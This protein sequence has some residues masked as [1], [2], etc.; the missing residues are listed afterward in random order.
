MPV[1]SPGRTAVFVDGC[2]LPFQRAGT[3]Y[4]DLMAYDMGRMVLRHLLTRTGLPSDRVERV[5]MGTV[6][7]DVNTSNVARESALAAGIPNHVPA[8]TVTM[9][10]ISSNQAVTSGVDLLRTGQADVMIAGGTETL[11]D[12]PVRLKRPVRKR[13]FQARKAKSTGDYLDLLD[14]LSPGD[15]LPETPA[16]AEFSTGEVMGESA[17]RLAAMFG[18][19]R[20]D[21]DRYALRSHKK[22]AAAR[23]D[24]RLDEELAPAT[25]PPAFDPIT[26]DNVIRDDTS[27]E[28]LRDLPPAFVEPFGTITAGSSSALTDGASAT[29]LMA[30]EVAEAEGVAP[31]AALRTYTYV[32]QD[33]ETE[34]LLGP[35]YAIPEV[36]DEAGLT[37]DDIDVIELHEAFA[38]QVLAVL[39]A[40]RSDTFAAEHLNRT[41]AVGAVEMDR[42]NTRGGSLS[43]G[44]PFGATGARLVM[45][46][47]NRLHDEDGRWALV[48][49]CAAGGQGHALL[50]ERRPS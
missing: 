8:F 7:Q 40:L 25:V 10:C 27:L 12:P 30:E 9:A 37:L 50:L 41:E 26:T 1:S 19:S 22:A 5:V 4:A 6:V 11:S 32:A 43:L 35:A 24:G 45:S 21:Q 38:G 23:D 29:L 17:D 36:L 31:R 47:V 49:A 2:R 13:L 18:I 33:P 46:A 20:E 42:L 16:I 44:H 14:G 3:G 28:Q 34:L 15:L 39:E 48:S